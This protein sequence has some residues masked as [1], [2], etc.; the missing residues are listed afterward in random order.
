MSIKPWI[1]NNQ[2]VYP[3]SKVKYDF[4]VKGRIG[5]QGLSADEMLDEGPYVITGTDFLNGEVDWANVRHVS[6]ERYDMAPEIQLKNGDLVIT[7]DGTIG[8]VAIIR[9]M[10]LPSTLNSGLFLVRPKHKR[11]KMDFFKYVIESNVFKDFFDYLSTGST[12]KHLYQDTFINFSYPLPPIEA[13]TKIVDYLNCKTTNID[14]YRSNLVTKRQAL[15]DLHSALLAQVVTKGLVQ[16]VPL[17]DTGQEWLGKIPEHWGL[18]PLK[19]VTKSYSGGTPSKDNLKYWS[20]GSIPWV[21]AKDMKSFFIEKTQDYITEDA[22]KGSSTK[23]VPTNSILIV[24]RSGILKKRVPVAVTRTPVTINQD[25]KVYE[26][27]KKELNSE[28]LANYLVGREKD[29]LFNASALGATVDS[30]DSELLGRFPIVIPPLQEQLEINDYIRDK[31]FNLDKLIQ[32]I[33]EQINNLDEY[34]TTLITDVVTGNYDIS[35]DSELRE[36]HK[37]PM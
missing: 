22:I 35:K 34:R 12:I 2:N 11:I 32:V 8:K 24:V 20:N 4:I 36:K 7:K 26:V 28:F 19:Y 18:Q 37:S 9:D 16:D 30:L 33:N 23:L 29:L 6:I 31:R 14:Q 13:Q 5:W 10:P 27:T 3:V 21:S 17:K 15:L 1:S 25:I